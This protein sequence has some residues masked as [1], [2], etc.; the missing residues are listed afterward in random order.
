MP[1]EVRIVGG[2]VL[3]A[4]ARQM[5]TEGR[6]DLSRDLA[7][8]LDRVAQPIKGDIRESAVQTMPSG[9]KWTLTRSLQ[10]RTVVRAGGQR[11]ALRLITTAKGV[12]EN[13]DVPSLERGRLRHPLWGE[14]EAWYDTKIRAG[15]HERGTDKASDRAVD[16]LRQVVRDFSARLIN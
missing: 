3:A 9:Y 2:A 12:H 8:A 1:V 11:A 14:R 6:K 4:L 7:K 16:E 5:R 13:R 10:W 15:F